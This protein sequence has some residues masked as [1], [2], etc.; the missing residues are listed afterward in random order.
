MKL[1]PLRTVA[2]RAR[3]GSLLVLRRTI[4][5][6][7]D[8]GRLLRRAAFIEYWT[9]SADTRTSSEPLHYP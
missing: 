2:W 3:Q 9:A 4:E 6:I 7:V 1:S 5:L 8:G